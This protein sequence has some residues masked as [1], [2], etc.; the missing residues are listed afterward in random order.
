MAVHFIILHYFV[1]ADSTNPPSYDAELKSK[2]DTSNY[3]ESSGIDTTSKSFGSVVEVENEK[4]PISGTQLY[5]A[6]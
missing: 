6:S 2:L 3:P 5:I 4:P 1:T